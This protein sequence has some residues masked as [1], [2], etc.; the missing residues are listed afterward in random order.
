M[1]GRRRFRGKIVNAG[2]I[3]NSRI[4]FREKLEASASSG[5]PAGGGGAGGLSWDYSAPPAVAKDF[6]R[7]WLTNG[8][9]ATLLHRAGPD[10]YLGNA[11][12]AESITYSA[13]GLATGLSIDSGTGKLNGTANPVGY[14]NVTVT[15]SG[16]GS[17]I[18]KTV[19]ICQR[20]QSNYTTPGTYTFV[21]PEFVDEISAVCV[22][23]GKGGQ[24]AAANGGG[25][26]GLRWISR[27]PVAPGESFTV[28]A[29]APGPGTLAPGSNN[30]AGGNSSI[31]RVSDSTVILQANGATGR[32]GGGGT[33]IGNKPYG[34]YV[35]GGNG[36]TTGQRG[37][38]GAGGYD[39]NALST[40]GSATIG[41]GRISFQSPGGAGMGG[42]PSGNDSGGGGGVGLYGRGDNGTYGMNP[43]RIPLGGQE[44]S[45][46]TGG[47]NFPGGGG[48]TYGGGG[49]HA[50]GP[51]TSTGGAGGK[52]GVRIIWGGPDRNY[53]GSYPVPAVNT[54]S[55][56]DL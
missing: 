23:G 5:A 54:G 41:G 19:Y 4:L 26:G 39:N 27:F 3:V 9:P 21:V 16:G 15:A 25:G 10:V 8:Q 46:G 6:Q 12:G 53:P 56:A 18:S 29:G 42:F 52:G 20:S 50:P 45:G 32:P 38:G 36:G 28:V 17:S 35:G 14:S 34:G 44:G 2:G 40:P 47:G 24:G 37:G 55:M 1:T 13:S 11:T 22:G 31:T 51:S 49:G 7:V 30:Q 48:G 33:T 43:G